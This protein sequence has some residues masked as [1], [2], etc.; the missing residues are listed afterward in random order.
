MTD[1]DTGFAE[2][3]ARC[4]QEAEREFGDDAALR[5]SCLARAARD[6]LPVAGVGLGLARD[7][8][9]I[10]LGASDGVAALAERLQYTLGDG[11]GWES[12]R[13]GQPLAA[14]HEAIHRRWSVFAD[15]LFA[16]TPYRA[17]LSLPLPA[18]PDRL[19]GADLYL[20]DETA[21]A[22]VPFADVATTMEL[23]VAGLRPASDT[24]LL[25]S[26]AAAARHTVW[27]AAGMTMG[28]HALDGRDALDLLRAH[29]IAHDLVLDELARRIV[30]R[31][32]DV[33]ALEEAVD[34]D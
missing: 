4:L 8:E 15:Q 5:P 7:G 6:V 27:V 24:D 10:P 18:F 2:Q 33:P 31:E 13:N 16:R 23:L 17:V 22:T 20:T 29:S 12:T 14:D 32:I 3:F 34:G 19:F 9:Q 11:P 26:P 30:A 1:R 28:R 21:L 25:A